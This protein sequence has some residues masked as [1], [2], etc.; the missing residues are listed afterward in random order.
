MKKSR[1]HIWI[2]SPCTPDRRYV[3]LAICIAFRSSF[4]YKL[5]QS[6]FE[7]RSFSGGAPPFGCKK[8]KENMHTH[9]P[10]RRR[11]TLVPLDHI[12]MTPTEKKISHGLKRRTTHGA[13]VVQLRSS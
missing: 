9:H 7:M 5:D 12:K 2:A 3:I 4:P 6:P 8:K 1:V 11:K 10:D 13:A